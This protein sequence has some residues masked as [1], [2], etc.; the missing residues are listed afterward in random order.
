M[1]RAHSHGIGPRADAAPDQRHTAAARTVDGHQGVHSD[2]GALRGEHP[3]R[4]ASPSIKVVGSGLAG[5]REAGPGRGRAIPVD[6][7]FMVAD[8]TP[9]TLVLR[10]RRGGPP[11]L[12]VRR[13]RQSRFVGPAF[14]GGGAG[15]PG[16]ARPGDGRQCATAS[17]R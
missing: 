4:P 7:G 17:R 6:F 14:A 2:S 9:E 12:V 10:A 16:P 15:G 1:T 3:G 5:V 11:S 13:G 8:R